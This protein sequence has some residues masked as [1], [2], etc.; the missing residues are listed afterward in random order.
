MVG[1]PCHVF[2]KKNKKCESCYY[3]GVNM[4]SDP[5]VFCN[6]YDNFPMFEKNPLPK[7]LKELNVV[8]KDNE[9]NNIN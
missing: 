4:E 1:Y 2:M 5:C 9:F 7:T 8:T 6:M 3:N